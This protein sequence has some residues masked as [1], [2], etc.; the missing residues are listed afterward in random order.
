MRVIQVD[1]VTNP[2][3]LR[4]GRQGENE[5][6]QVEF[7]VG[8]FAEEF[9]AGQPQLV[10]QRCSDTTPYPVVL[11]VD[12]DV[13]TWTVTAT[14][15]AKAGHGK[16]QLIYY[17]DS[18]I[19]KTVTYTIY[20]AP[21][22]SQGNVPPD[23]YESYLEQMT[24]I[25]AQVAQSAEDVRDAV[26]QAETTITSAVTQ[27]ESDITSAVTQAESSITSTAQTATQSI[28][29]TATQAISSVNSTVQTAT[30]NITTTAQQALSTINAAVT[31]AQEILEEM[32]ELLENHNGITYEE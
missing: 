5:T 25:G 31:Q 22:V 13:A 30:Q 15:T 26:E 1:C 21:S 18:Q 23:P 29:T 11:T 12:G 28:T 32:Q 16:A 19:A 2:F 9:G 24:E 6:T 27:A 8:S 10:V 4:I 14:D 3:T 20:V 17:V 7:D